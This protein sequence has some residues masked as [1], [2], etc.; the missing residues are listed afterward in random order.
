MQPRLPSST[1]NL[2]LLWLGWSAILLAFQGTI[3][4]RLKLFPPDRAL[5]WT[6][7]ETMPGS[8]AGK[9]YLNEPFLNTQVAWDSEYYLSIAV[10]GYDDPAVAGIHRDFRWGPGMPDFCSPGIDSDCTSRSYAFFPLYP[11]LIRLVAWPLQFLPLGLIGCTALAAV[12][13]SLLGTLGA[14]LS[15]HAMTGRALGTEG[16]LRAAFYLLIFPSGFFLAQVYTEGLFLAVTFGCLA[17]LLERKWLPAALLATLA[18]WTRPGGHILLLPLA[19]AWL[20]DRTW[21]LGWKTALLRL[22]AVLAPVISYVLW[23]FSPLAPRFSLVEGRFF[24]RGLFALGRSLEAW[25]TAWMALLSGDPQSR[26]YYALEFAAILL[27]IACCLLLLRERPEL[28]LFGLAMIVFALTSGA[29]QGMIRY[30]LVVPPLFWV[31]ARWGR[32]P[33]FDRLWSLASILLLGIQSML[34]TFD[35]WVA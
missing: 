11:F 16:A 27:G 28:A 5:P 25:Q 20:M 21:T 23:L 13:I 4:A 33:V 31:L 26:F 29:A 22:L 2:L 10:T 12:M 30:V 14:I 24:G 3:A 15:L 32:Q 19:V 17:C 9:I 35:F 18:C 1:R 34:F 6:A 7:A 8:Q